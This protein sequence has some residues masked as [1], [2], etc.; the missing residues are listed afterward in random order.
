MNW[1]AKITQATLASVVLLS[2]LAPP[3]ALAQNDD[4]GWANVRVIEVRP[5]RQG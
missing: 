5:D 4:P 2:V 1:I 3:Q